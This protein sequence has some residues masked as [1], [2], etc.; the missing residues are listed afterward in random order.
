MKYQGSPSA[1]R[2]AWQYAGQRIA[3]ELRHHRERDAGVAA[4]RLEELASRLELARGLRGL[5]H[6]LRDP[7]LDR[8]GWVLALEL[9]VEPGA[10]FGAYPR[11]LDKGGAADRLEQGGGQRSLA[12]R[13][14]RQKDHRGTVADRRLQAVERADVLVVH[15]DVHE[16][17]D[18]VPVLEHLTAEA[19]EALGQVGQQLANRGAG[20]VDLPCAADRIA[21]RGR[22]PDAG[23]EATCVLPPW[24][25]S[26]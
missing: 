24:Q 26:T 6:R 21:E 25:N 22:D 7:V 19:W 20:G 1:R 14:R 23:H 3:L 17:G 10:A 12:A 13:H 9:R 5:D 4:R 11:E 8:T 16:R 2:S 18:L 15:V